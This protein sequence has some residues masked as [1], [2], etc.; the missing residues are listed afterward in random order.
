[1]TDHDHDDEV[2]GTMAAAL[3]AAR[4]TLPPA[5]VV[6]TTGLTRVAVELLRAARG[7]AITVTIPGVPILG[8]DGE[9]VGMTEATTSTAVLAGLI[10]TDDEA[11][12]LG[13]DPTDR[14]PD[15]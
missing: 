4:D 15:A 6:P 14:S 13:V 10:I 11:A 1:M 5:D 12:R 2:A 3:S 9:M 8:P 7:K